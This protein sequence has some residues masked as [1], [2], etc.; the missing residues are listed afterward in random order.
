[1]MS[2]K[3]HEM[4]LFYCAP[5]LIG[6]PVHDLLVGLEGE[7]GDLPDGV[8]HALAHLDQFAVVLCRVEA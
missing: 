2:Y 6:N 8:R 1:M 7:V 3:S 4:E 5:L